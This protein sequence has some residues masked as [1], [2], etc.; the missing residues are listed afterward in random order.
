[1]KCIILIL[2]CNKYMVH[3]TISSAKQSTS[4]TDFCVSKLNIAS[5][6]DWCNNQGPVFPKVIQSDFGSWIGSNLEN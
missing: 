3:N 4:L 1:M 2:Q 6:L 5:V